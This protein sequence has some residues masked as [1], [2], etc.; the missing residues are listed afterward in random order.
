MEQRLSRFHRVD[1]G[2]KVKAWGRVPPL[3]HRALLLT[4]T[5]FLLAVLDSPT[6]LASCTQRT[7]RCW[8]RFLTWF[9]S[10]LRRL[11]IPW[12]PSVSSSKSR[13]SWTTFSNS[14]RLVASV[15]HRGISTETPPFGYISLK[16][17][18]IISVR[19]RYHCCKI[20]PLI[21]LKGSNQVLLGCDEA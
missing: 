2:I 8:Q 4:V 9:A 20:L 17:Y 21:F 5:F 10:P 3:P 14:I 19:L 13:V 6:R 7:K 15:E 1:G 16:G 18:H 11:P 12:T